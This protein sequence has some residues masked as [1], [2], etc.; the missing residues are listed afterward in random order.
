MVHAGL[1]GMHAVKHAPRMLPYQLN[2]F[3]FMLVRRLETVEV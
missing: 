1:R 2:K 3:T